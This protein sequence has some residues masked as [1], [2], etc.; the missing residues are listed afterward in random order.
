MQ[1]SDEQEFLDIREV[2]KKALPRSAAISTVEFEGPEIAIYSKAPKILLDDGDSIKALARKMRKRI[3]VRSAPEVRLTHEEAEKTV[4]EL[5]PEEAMITSIDFDISRGEVIIEAQKPGLVI[6]RSGTTLQEITRQT[7]WRPN[8]MRT[9]P[10]ESKLIKQIRYI[11]QSEAATRNKSF[12]EI[13]KRIHRPMLMNNSWI[14]LVAMGGFR[15]VGR[16]CMFLQTPESNVIIDCGVNVGTPS[17]AFPRLDMPE[18]NVEDLDAVVI[19]HAHLDHCGMVP[20]LFKY[21]YRGPVYMTAPTLNLATLLQLDYLEVAER[22]GKLRPYRDRDV[23]ETILHTIPLNYG[24][25][26]D[27]APDVR[28]TLHNAGHI[29]GSAIVH[30]HIGDG[31]YNMAYTGD[32]KFGRSRLLEPATFTFPRLETMILESTYG[33]PTDKMPPRQEVEKKFATIIKRA[34]ERGGK[35]LI[36]VL[37]VGRAQEIM[38]VIEDLVSKGRIPKVPVYIEGMI[39]QATAIHTTHPEALS[40]KIREMIFHQG[41]NPFL[42][43]IFVQV[44]HHEQREEITEGEPCIIMATSGMLAGGPSVDYFRLLAPD[45][46]NMLTFVSYQGENTLGRRIQK[47]WKEANMRN[48]DGQTTVVPIN[49]EVTTV[50]GFSGHSDRKQILNFVKRLSP[51]PERIICVHGEA[52][53]TIGLASTIHKAMN[54][55]T[56][57]PMV[58]ETTKLR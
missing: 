57:A 35:V 44:D 20:F 43:E 30:F 11:I 25:V 41:V 12:R 8:V 16:S 46:R 48:R 32:F 27:I 55:E 13:G 56:R 31:Q 36:P 14:R 26:T 52:S 34:L 2:I 1:P 4:R 38:L 54:I 21:G 22:E 58:T 10:I 5:V 51:I 7:F 24:E 53:K 3:V 29:L 42:S 40:K 6:G 33:H 37:A 17:K 23:K 15:E 19:T 9:P 50:E 45:E 28:L 39:A 18:F 47:G 49:L